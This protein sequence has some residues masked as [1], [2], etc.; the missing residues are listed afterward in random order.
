MFGT[1]PTPTHTNHLLVIIII[2]IN[3][4]IDITSLVTIDIINI[5]IDQVHPLLLQHR[6]L[7]HD[8]TSHGGKSPKPSSTVDCELFGF[9][10]FGRI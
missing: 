2:D 8:S 10:I 9:S 5:V 1:V 4:V 6:P 7:Q 3:N